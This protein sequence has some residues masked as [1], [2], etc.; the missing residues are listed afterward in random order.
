MTENMMQR[1]YGSYNETR[2]PLQSVNMNTNQ[3]SK[4]K[5]HVNE[6]NFNQLNQMSRCTSQES[7]MIGYFNFSTSLEPVRSQTQSQLLQPTQQKL[8]SGKVRAIGREDDGLYI[9]ERQKIGTSLAVT[10]GIKES[11]Q[12]NS[13]TTKEVD[14][15]HKRF[16]HASSTVL[17]MLLHSKTDLIVDTVKQ[18]VVCPCAKQSNYH[19]LSVTLNL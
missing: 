13:T 7:N 3:G 6:F 17:K 11:D 19:L 1:T 8:F 4:D 2:G 5:G 12:N 16:G 10:A 9:L 18:C 14:L 15:W